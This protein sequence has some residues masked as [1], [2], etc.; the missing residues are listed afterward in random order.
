VSIRI[1]AAE[2]K[3]YLLLPGDKGN[4][5]LP[6]SDPMYVEMLGLAVPLAIK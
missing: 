3:A 4:A 2:G 5:Q 1:E 6:A